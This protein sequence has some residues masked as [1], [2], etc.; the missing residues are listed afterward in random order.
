LLWS[1]RRGGMDS[2]KE[3]VMRKISP[4]PERILNGGLC[5]TC[6]NA[7]TC[8]Y[9]RNA[10][11]P[12]LHCEEFEESPLDTGKQPMEAKM[13]L[14]NFPEDPQEKPKYFGLCANCKHRETC[15]FPKPPGGVWHCE[16]YE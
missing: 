14:V 5:A 3:R 13:S 11:E 8:M 7:P 16:E 10:S 6:R 4:N 9:L 1:R 12:I 2:E 15:K